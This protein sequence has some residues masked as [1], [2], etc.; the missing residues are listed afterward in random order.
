L[1][2]MATGRMPFAGESIT[3]TIDKITHSH[4]DAI[5]RFNYDIP[6]E[7]EVIIKKALR[8]KREERYQTAQ[9]ILVDLQSLARELDLTEHSVAPNLQNASGE[10]SAKIHTDEQTTKTLIQTQTVGTTAPI[11]TTSSAEYIAGEIK[12]HKKGVG[13]ALIAFLLVIAGVGFGLYKYSTKESNLA[14]SSSPSS[15]VMKVARLTSTGKVTRAAVSPDGKYAVHVVDEAGQQSLWFRQIAT[16]SNVNVLPPA[17]VNYLGLTFSQDGNYVYFVRREKAGN[18]G[19]VYRMDT[20]GGSSRKVI[21]GAD[22]AVTLSPDGKQL[23]FI[24]YDYNQGE[25]ALIIANIDGSGERK[26]AVP[27]EPEG[28]EAEGLAWSPDGKVIACSYYS[29]AADEA[30][31]LV[32]VAVEDGRAKPILPQRWGSIRS[33]TW[34]GDGSGLLMSAADKSSGYFYQIWHVAYPN[35]EA[36]R[37]TN[38]LNSYSDVSVT[39]DS[40][41]LLAVQ[42]DWVSNLWIAPNGDSSRAQ[43][44]T[45]GKYDGGMG[46]AW[47]PDGR[48]VHASRDWDISILDADGSNQKLLTIDEHSNRWVSVTP[49]GRY[50]LFESWRNIGGATTDTPI[51]R[52]DIDGGNPK[53]LAGKGWCSAPKASPDGKWVVYESNASGK[54]TLWKTSIDGGEAKQ[55]T[56]KITEEPAIS[57]DGKL[58]ACFYYPEGQSIKIAVL[59]FEGGEFIYEFDVDQSI[60]DKTPRWTPDGRA[61]TYILNRG[62]VSNIWSQPLGGGAPKQLTDFKTDRIFAFDWSRDGKQ[63]LLSRG[64]ISNDVVLIQDFR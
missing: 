10:I 22:G 8:K 12:R 39:A 58:I 4:P 21:E 45:S 38:D 35:G 56:D 32:E 30:V 2:E 18:K 40:N 9:D 52:M 41:T 29:A 50:I 44:I 14:P 17:E 42:G 25:S 62:G 34:L 60:R 64:T 7:L 51:W 36:R 57:P 31:G 19:T 54:M 63:L 47:T 46:V 15:Q 23:A 28:F 3:E 37:I 49:D 20:L 48:I 24:R 43:R 33:V 6:P 16:A 61:I 59:P 27:K 13:I 55:L 5:A 11:H 26:L 1:Y 53:P